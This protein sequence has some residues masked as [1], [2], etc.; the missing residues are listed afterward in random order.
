M[1]RTPE[2]LAYQSAQI[3]AGF[4][5]PYADDAPEDAPGPGLRE[6]F[7]AGARLVMNRVTPS[8]PPAEDIRVEDTPY[9]PELVFDYGTSGTRVSLSESDLG[10]LRKV[11]NDRHNSRDIFTVE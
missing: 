8:R 1:E 5:N 2:E 7:E 3:A 11:L 10:T 6:S 4:G 9:G